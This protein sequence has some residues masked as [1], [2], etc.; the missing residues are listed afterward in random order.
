ME[1]IH[2]VNESTQ[3][4]RLWLIQEFFYNQQSFAHPTF[5][6]NRYHVCMICPAGSA[7][8]HPFVMYANAHLCHLR[9]QA[10]HFS[11]IGLNMQPKNDAH[12]VLW[13]TI[14]KSVNNI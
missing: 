2:T 4:M 13:A 12:I 6:V 9:V 3:L 8:K 14:L 10:L 11:H 5:N 1:V 7:V